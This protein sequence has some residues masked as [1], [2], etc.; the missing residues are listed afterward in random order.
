MPCRVDFYVSTSAQSEERL[1]LACRVVEKAY[2]SGQ[3]VYLYC[4]NPEQMSEMDQRLWTFSQSSFVPHALKQDR[5][6]LTP[7]TLGCDS[8]TTDFGSIVVSLAEAPVRAFTD[9]SRVAEIVGTE[10]HERQSAR[11]RYKFYRESGV[12]P[13]THKV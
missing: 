3:S 4:Q 6:E 8:P 10:E 13:S 11:E 5:D 7:V 1:T 2:K 12:E 9:F